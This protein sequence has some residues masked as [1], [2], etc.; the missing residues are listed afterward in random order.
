LPKDAEGRRRPRR[1]SGFESSKEAQGELDEVRALLALPEREDAAARCKVGDLLEPVFRDGKPIPAVDVVRRLLRASVPV[2]EQPTVEQWLTE[3]LPTK[4]KLSRNARRSYESH[5]RLY[6]VPY[7]G[8]VRLDRL[9]VA[10]VA[11]M[12]EQIAEH[13]EEIAAARESKDEKRREAVKWQ[14]PVGVSSMHRIRETLRAALNAAIR[15]ELLTVNPAKWVEMPPGERPKAR[16]WTSERVELWRATGQVPSPVMVWTPEQTG[17]FLDHAVHDRLYPL[18]HLIA[19]RGLRRGEGCGLHWTETHLEA[20]T[21]EVT[22]QIV[23]YGWETGQTK[24][25]TSD[26]DATVA[27]DAGTVAVLAEHRVRQRA[28]LRAAGERWAHTGLVFTAEDGSALHPAEVT[29]RFRFLARQAGL[30]PIRLHD[31]RHGAAT[32]ALAAGVDMKVVQ[33]MLRHASISTTS[34]LYTS[35]LPKAA[36]EAAE[37]TALIIPR[38]SARLLGRGS[39]TGETTVDGAGDHRSILNAT[40]AQVDDDIDLRLCGAPPGTR[41]PNPLVKSQL[42]CQLS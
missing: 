38:T 22:N 35:V 24:P 5:I 40:K 33:A 13:N 30:P 17:Q 8:G 41:T 14:R 10:H 9:R 6:L 42:L 19:H 16:V 12:F 3:W 11:D 31:L 1:R 26:S 32:L 39:G 27:L 18:F 37:K 28:E 34:D 25:K 21:I 20:G 23:Q 29:E 15:Q 4:K 36:R 2:L 7:L